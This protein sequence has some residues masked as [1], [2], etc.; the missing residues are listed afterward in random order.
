MKIKKI[1]HIIIAIPFSE[2]NKRN[3]IIQEAIKN[4]LAV[5]TSPDLNELV[6]GNTDSLKLLDLGME[7]LL[8]RKKVEPDL[9][10]MEKDIKSQTV[11]VSGAGGTIEVS[12]VEKFLKNNPDKI[13]L[14]DSNEYSLYSI[15]NELEDLNEER[16]D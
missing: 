4:Q 15:Q 7:D 1:T 8:E 10:L 5:R 2:R 12:Y 13:L 6:L 11:L 9:K 14:L 16:H 3:L